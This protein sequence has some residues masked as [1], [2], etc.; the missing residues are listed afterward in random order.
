MVTVC[1]PRGQGSEDTLAVALRQG[2]T[3]T[4]G[5]FVLLLI[6]GKELYSFPHNMI[7]VFGDLSFLY[8]YFLSTGHFKKELYGVFLTQFVFL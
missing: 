7:M 5:A 1:S 3:M 8:L 2:V 4:A 6:S